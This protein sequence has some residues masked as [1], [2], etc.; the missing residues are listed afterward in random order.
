MFL[1]ISTAFTSLIALWLIVLSANV[2]FRRRDAKVSLGDGEDIMLTRRIRAQA[3]LIEYAPVMMVMVAL[4]ELQGGNS[5]I[6]GGLAALFFVARLA[7]G[8]ALSFSANSPLGR[9]F[10]A[11]VT[12]LS[13]IVLALYNLT[14]L[15][16]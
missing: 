6:V 3:N 2:I 8:Y 7:H 1:P 9:T 12:F 13:I 10:G 5:I 15:L 14:F 11:S 16:G 4:G